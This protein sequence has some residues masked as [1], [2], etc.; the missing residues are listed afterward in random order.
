MS[1]VKNVQEAPA[2]AEKPEREKVTGSALEARFDQWR[3][4]RR[5]KRTP[6]RRAR[7]GRLAVVGALLLALVG[8][9][10]YSGI[11]NRVHEE[12]MQQGT[13][14]LEALEAELVSAQEV[15]PVVV[16]DADSVNT[17]SSRASESAAQVAA[18]QQQFA[19][20]YFA[21][22]TAIAPGNGAPSSETL[23]IVEHRRALAD[24]WSPESLIVDESLAYAFAT[25]PYF[26]RTEIDPRFPWY[27]KYAGTQ[28][29]DPASYS[30]QVESVMPSLDAP[31]TAKVVWVAV[32]ADGSKLAWASAS[33]DDGTRMFSD[34]DLVVTT[35]GATHQS[36]TDA[37]KT[38]R[39]PELIQE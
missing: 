25:T 17:L 9:A 31:G 8:I 21:E 5:A 30:W 15:A 36:E 6:E 1:E 35:I 28:A 37:A 26:E 29:A 2:T 38:A 19:S 34:L 22:N 13:A 7:R 33:Y 39:L 14:Q 10:V 20:L 16:M 12:Q 23:A 3:A 32:D 24:N 18:K 11:A 4:A 27:V